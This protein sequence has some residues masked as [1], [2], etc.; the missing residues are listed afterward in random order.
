MQTSK[1]TYANFPNYVIYYKQY[2]SNKDTCSFGLNFVFNFFYIH[3]YVLIRYTSL[4]S[5]TCE[6]L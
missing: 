4:S 2:D 3:N 6:E 1:V 5:F